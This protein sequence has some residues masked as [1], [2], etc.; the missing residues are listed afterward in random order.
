MAVVAMAVMLSLTS[1]CGTI[2]GAAVGSGVTYEIMHENNKVTAAETA[3]TITNL[4]DK[5][6]L[7]KEQNERQQKEILAMMQLAENARMQS[8]NQPPQRVEQAAPTGNWGAP[9]VP[10]AET[11]FVKRHSIPCGSSGDMVLKMWT[12][13]PAVIHELKAD[14]Y[15]VDGD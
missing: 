5:V 14:G 13:K 2:I 1:G 4:Q 10:A 7:L 12:G 15:D 9:P 3:N 11:A 8:R 6:G